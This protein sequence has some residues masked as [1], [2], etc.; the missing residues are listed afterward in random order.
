MAAAAIRYTGDRKSKDDKERM[1]SSPR[2][3]YLLYNQYPP[4]NLI[5]QNRVITVELYIIIILTILKDSPFS[6]NKQFTK[7]LQAEALQNVTRG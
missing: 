3:I 2:F 4:D 6:F 5:F 1:I 7:A